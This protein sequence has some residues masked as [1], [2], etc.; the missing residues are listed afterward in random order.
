MAAKNWTNTKFNKLT[1]IELTNNYH[2]THR[3]WKL[4]CECG[5]FIEAT[6]YDVHQRN[7]KSCGCDPTD[8]FKDWTGFQREKLTFIKRSGNS[9]RMQAK[10][11]AQCECGRTINT[12]P[13]NEAKSC[14][15]I[16]QEE[17]RKRC[18]LLGKQARKHHP[19]ISSAIHV[20]RR[21]KDGNITFEKFLEL[22]QLP[23]DYCGRIKVH[24]YK[25]TQYHGDNITVHPDGLFEYNGLDRIDSNG[26]HDLDNVVPCCI[27]CNMAKG[28]KPRSEFL[29]HIKRMYAH[30]ILE[31]NVMF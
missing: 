12:I 15:C 1:F 16:D 29:I 22:S 11:L 19:R 20:W 21:Y 18:S 3:L 6:P 26:K 31:L 7:R 23:C 27:D 30:S 28:V 4:Q 9:K 24:K 17:R 5:N 25:L 10:W 8:R 13:S 14:G 2:G